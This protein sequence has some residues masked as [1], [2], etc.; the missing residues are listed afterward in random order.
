MRTTGK[1]NLSSALK[2]KILDI[3]DWNMDTTASVS[4]PHGLNLTSIRGWSVVIR[5]DANANYR[6]EP[7]ITAGVPDSLIVSQVDAT[8]VGITRAASSVFDSVNFDSTSFNRG[9]IT[10]YYA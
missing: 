8:N 9:W 10:I 3:G 4:I 2:V 1:L 5:D 7:F 6:Q